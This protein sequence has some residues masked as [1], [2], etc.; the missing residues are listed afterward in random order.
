[1]RSDEHDSRAGSV[2]GRDGTRRLSPLSRC[3]A[4]GSPIES[5]PAG[6]DRRRHP[7]ATSTVRSGTPLC[8]SRVPFHGRRGHAPAGGTF[9]LVGASSRD[10]R[11]EAANDPRLSAGDGQGLVAPGTCRSS[12][13]RQRSYGRRGAG[14]PAWTGSR[15]LRGTGR[16]V[17]IRV[18]RRR[19]GLRLRR[20][21]RRRCAPSGRQAGRHR[22]RRRVRGGCNGAAPMLRFVSWFTVFV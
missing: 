5:L 20:R 18:L 6:P 22:R 3:P 12:S 7:A 4:H 17:P 1:M 13:G 14:C 19:R 10:P 16:R 15:R 9:P 11:L 2:S 21:L 8:N